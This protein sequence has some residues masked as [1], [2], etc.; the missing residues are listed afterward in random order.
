[1]RANLERVNIS[2][3][4]KI[5]EGVQTFNAAG[6]TEA[7]FGNPKEA[8]VEEGEVSYEA[9]ADMLVTSVHEALAEMEA[10]SDTN[11]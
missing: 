11:S 8:S 2:I 3:A 10:S 9:L 4:D 6:A 5:R 1:M 7:Y